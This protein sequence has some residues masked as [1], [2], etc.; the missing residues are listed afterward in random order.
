MDILLEYSLLH[1]QKKI[2][3]NQLKQLVMQK[4]HKSEQLEVE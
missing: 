2:V 3:P 4:H 1:S